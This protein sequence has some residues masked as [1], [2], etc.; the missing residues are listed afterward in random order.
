MSAAETRSG[1]SAE[2]PVRH[3]RSVPGCPKDMVYGPCGGVTT[4]GGCEVHDRPCP[5][6]DLPATPVWP[7]RGPRPDAELPPVDDPRPCSIWA[8]LRPDPSRASEALAAADVLGRAGTGVLIGEH[9]DDPTPHQPGEVA[10]AVGSAVPVIAT[11]T[12]RGRNDAELDQQID[13]LVRLGVHA[14]HCVTGDHPAGRLGLDVW[15]DFGRDGTELAARAAARGALVS[16]AE[17]P[18]SPP[19]SQRARRV[20]SKEHAGA[21]L[22]ILNHAGA[23]ADLVRFADECRTLGVTAGLVAP[24][25]VIT[26]RRSAVSLDRFPGL[27]LPPGL[28]SR[29]LG[30]DDPVA[31][32]I[33][34]AVRMG[35]DLLSSGRFQGVNLSGSGSD[36]GILGRA[37][38]MASIA[39]EVL[40]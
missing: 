28:T 36:T 9:L 11:V 35:R 39:E 29:V 5:F 33:E 31:E 12:C 6:V 40:S 22:V 18:A 21:D 23:T 24:V 3:R 16:V 14:V 13:A 2:E 27:R 17:S 1:R 19:T 38:L 25:P 37:H 30:A 8:D 15:P 10:A 32:G 7:A 34:A 26:D 4:G 20:L